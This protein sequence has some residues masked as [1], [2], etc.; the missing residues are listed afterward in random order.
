M[1]AEDQVGFSERRE[2]ARLECAPT[3]EGPIRRW[4]CPRNK[5]TNRAGKQQIELR[6]NKLQPSLLGW[7]ICRKTSHA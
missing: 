5:A 1:N 2:T 4:I 3:A 7:R 6:A